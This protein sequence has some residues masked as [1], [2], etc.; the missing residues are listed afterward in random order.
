[1]GIE[2]WTRID[3]GEYHGQPN[4][5]ATKQSKNEPGIANLCMPDGGTLVQWEPCQQNASGSGRRYF[6]D[7][8]S[9]LVIGHRDRERSG[10]Q[11]SNLLAV[12]TGCV[13]QA[14]FRARTIAALAF[15]LSPTKDRAN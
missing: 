6:P 11:A 13:G 2:R 1:M 12:L 7:A 10:A 8:F 3:E 15:R 9:D 14:G 4:P 5:G